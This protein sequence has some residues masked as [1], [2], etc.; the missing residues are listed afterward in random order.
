MKISPT[1]TALS[2]AGLVWRLLLLSLL[3]LFIQTS[4]AQYCTSNATS[5]ID[6]D[7]EN[8]LLKGNTITLDNFSGNVTPCGTYADYTTGLPVPDLTA[9]GAYTIYIKSKTCGGNYNQQ[10]QAWI[11]Y[12]KNNVFEAS[13]ALGTTYTNNGPTTFAYNFTVP[14]N[15]ATGTTR[16]RVV[17]IET[18]ALNNPGHACGTYTYG[19]TEDYTVSLGT[20]TAITAN[21]LVPNTIWIKTVASFANANSAGNNTNAWDANNDGS[22]EGTSVN[23][24]YTWN[25]AGNKCVK[26]KSSNCAGSDSIVKCFNVITPTSIPVANFVANKTAVEIYD[27]VKMFDLSTNGA[28]IWTWDVY[29]SVTYASQ[30]IYPSLANGEV[31]SDP[32]GNGNTEFTQNPEFA[33]EKP[34]AY[35]VTLTARNDV[36]TSVMFS[37]TLYIIVSTSTDY[38]LGFG[39]YGPNADNN[40]ESPS[41]TIYDNGGPFANYSS[42]MGLGSRSFLL[43]TP[44]NA[45]NI[46]LTMTEL[47]FADAGDK[48]SVYDGTSINAPL[49][50]SWNNASTAPAKVNAKSG[51]MYILFESNSSG[52]S[53]G[54][55]GSY[56]ATLGPATPTT[57]T[58]ITPTYM[59]NS[60]PAT[61]INTTQNI[62]GIPG[63]TWTIDGIEPV[64]AAQKDLKHAFTTD[65]VYE[66]CLEIKSCIGNKKSCDSV[67][68][69]TPNTPTDV[70]FTASNFRPVIK[71]E[72]VTLKPLTD[73]ANRFEWSISPNTY[74]VVNPPSS[75][76]VSGPGFIKYYSTPNNSIPEPQIKFNAPG[77]YTIFL[78]AWN[79]LDSVNTTNSILKIDYVCV[80][81]YCKPNSFIL[82]QDV[83]INRVVVRDGNN[84][85]I[86]NNST[87]GVDGYSDF[88]GTQKANLTYGKTYTLELHRDNSQDPANRTGWVD[89]NFDGDFTDSGEQIF[90]EA[91]TYNKSYTTTFRV[92]A[93]SNSL[94]GTTRLRVGISYNSDNAPACGPVNVGEYEDYGLVLSRDNAR[95][96]ITLKGDDTVFIEV[97]T[98]YNDSGARA[99]DASEGDISSEIESTTD[100][101]IN[102]V[103]YYTYEYNVTDKSGNAAEPVIRHIYVL[104]DL[105][106]PI[107]TLNPGNTAC[108]E[109]NRLNPPYNDPGATATDN[110]APFNLNPSIKV[111]GFVDTRR[112]GT[113]T[114]TYSVMDVAGNKAS[115]TRNVCV[116][117]TKAPEIR[118]IGSTDV[119][120]GSVW[121]DNT[122]AYDD[123]DDN[124][125]FTKTWDANGIL[126]TTIVNDYTIEYKA[127][128]QSGNDTSVVVTYHVDDFIP[129]VINLNTLPVVYHEVR[130]PYVSVPVTVTDNY[131]SG[132]N[133]SVSPPVSNVDPTV[134]GTYTEVF[135]ARDA[136]GNK[137]TTTRT[138]I[139]VDTKAPKIWG[140]NI[141]GCVGENI[142]PMW[143]LSTTDNYYSPAQLKGLIQIVAQ[144]VNPMEEGWYTITYRVTDPSGNVS[145][146][147]TR[148]VIYTYWPKCVNS[149]VDVN[150]VKSLEES[151]SIYPN[152]GAGVFTVDLNG[153]MARDIRL[154][155][156]NS[157]GQS[158]LK[159]DI[160]EVSGKV[161]VDLTG[162]A[163]GVYVL[164]MISGDVVV[165]KRLVIK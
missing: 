18:T 31:L 143:G 58:F 114:L 34:G 102:S 96:V 15:I 152:P 4:R 22:I 32:L 159:Q 84:S 165:T 90:F 107:I 133:V 126:N 101:D 73:K 103:G 80:L 10:A 162:N 1:T 161:N 43:I 11:D 36:G 115:V 76:S 93:L 2:G 23:F 99:T 62:V 141:R 64:G 140:E 60:T 12:N 132:G 27:V 110:R 3:F 14:C 16:M 57:P 127:V 120:V 37:K 77:C 68:V 131:Y 138:V 5:T 30:G 83:G 7:M 134:L 29:D 41:G 79:S 113:Y 136:S 108:I 25:T 74:T 157:V 54:F 81:E 35:T 139:V 125:A 150:D 105:T 94:E 71:T 89:W 145:E 49:L 123:Y 21:F 72:V 45:T 142:W 48:L 135:S 128:D 109:A 116:V 51:S 42:N 92:P 8:V 19:E 52:V 119:Q 85:M 118:N 20:P 160:T 88:S 65:G 104:S 47:A 156:Y 153:I 75:P 44:C 163:G 55:S 147:F 40:V 33:F 17:V 117:D 67:S 66:V 78:R 82:S 164:K 6:T 146:N 13:E 59:Y 69:I 121:V 149:T 91:S 86:D 151:V 28:Y 39:L 148:N 130:T 46:E 137:S 97:G 98:T 158:V 100:L 155:V 61:F 50:A 38:S 87:S 53:K 122:S 129:P 106:K 144:N 26:L 154:E 70:D 9:G 112:I 124:P 56:K 24:N 63:W 95:P 111:S